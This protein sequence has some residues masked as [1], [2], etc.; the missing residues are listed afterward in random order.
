[1]NPAFAY[2]YDECLKEK[3]FERELQ[4]VENELARR[5][6]EGLTMRASALNGPKQMVKQLAQQG[7]KNLI[8]VGSDQIMRDVTPLLPEVNATIGFL[9]I[10]PSIIG[11]LLGIPSGTKA[12]DVIAARLVEKLD[13]GRVNGQPFLLDLVAPETIAGI[14]VGGAYRLRPSVKGAIAIRN[15]AAT[16][17]DGILVNPKDGQLEILIQAETG[18]VD[19]KW[20]W[21]KPQL[22]ETKVFLSEG[23]MASD[24]PFTVFVD[25]HPYQGTTFHFSVLPGSLTLITGR[26]LSD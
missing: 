23:S 24:A 8:L 25:G 22:S 11:G 9:P 5:G 19:K 20:P 2:V 4:L 7:I 10:G 6:I 18:A 13:M 21:R 14:E 16:G 17:Q 1:M 15:L 12:V 3:R 26:R